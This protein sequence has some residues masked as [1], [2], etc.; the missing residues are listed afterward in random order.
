MTHTEPMAPVIEADRNAAA[1]LV[2]WQQ[3][4]TEEWTRQ[5][6]GAIQFFA[7]ALPK[8]IRQG[9]W[10]EHPVVQAFARH[11]LS[12]QP[13]TAD[14][15]AVAR[16]MDPETWRKIDH[17]RKT[18]KLD[19]IS[20]ANAW[21][22]QSLDTARRAIAAVG[23]VVCA[24]EPTEAMVEGV[25]ERTIEWLLPHAGDP[26]AADLID[27]LHALKPAP[28][29]VQ[30]GREGDLA[31]RLSGLI[32]QAEREGRTYGF[33]IGIGLAKKLLAALAT[34]PHAGEME[35]VL[36]AAEALVAAIRSTYRDAQGRE[37]GIKD[38]SGEMMWLVP[39]KEMYRLDAAIRARTPASTDGKGA[40]E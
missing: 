3:K 27:E 32:R 5:D 7:G 13:I 35:A 26:E 22:E 21:T 33:D 8:G 20:L 37:K 2:C 11:R 12:Q 4:A 9:I 31:K 40:G 39:H 18:G 29:E 28:A 10:D 17:A 1:G 34:P 15:E 24:A 36:E 23:E 38:E 19:R 14:P 16:E 6:G 25:I 30:P